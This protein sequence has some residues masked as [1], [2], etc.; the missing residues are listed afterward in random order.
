MGLGVRTAL[1]DLGF[2][3]LPSQ[4]LISCKLLML[5]AFAGAVSL[6]L[7]GFVGLGET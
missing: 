5:I 2:I 4:H 6:S 3:K 1:F 7:G